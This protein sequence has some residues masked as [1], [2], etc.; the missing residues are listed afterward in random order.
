MLVRELLTAQQLEKRIDEVNAPRVH[1]AWALASYDL[2][3]TAREHEVPRSQVIRPITCLRDR[4]YFAGHLDGRSGVRGLN[5]MLDETHELRAIKEPLTEAMV[6]KQIHILRN[7]LNP[8]DRENITSLLRNEVRFQAVPEKIKNLQCARIEFPME[9]AT[10]LQ[11]PYALEADPVGDRELTVEYFLRD[12]A[13]MR[14]LWGGALPNGW[15]VPEKQPDKAGRKRERLE[16]QKGY[17]IIM[18]HNDKD[19]KG[20]NKFTYTRETKKFILTLALAFF[21]ENLN[22]VSGEQPPP[23]PE[24]WSS[25]EAAYDIVS[26]SWVNRANAPAWTKA[27]AR[28]HF[29]EC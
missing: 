14:E 12:E 15:V 13:E 26:M 16:S 22:F 2:V 10:F 25:T 5:L 1:E 6:N 3:L 18:M 11:V 17:M 24:G 9:Y 7:E 4:A 27:R 20:V 8:N 28:D 21:S 29:G 23:A 19:S